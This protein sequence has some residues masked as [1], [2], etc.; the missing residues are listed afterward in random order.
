MQDL[1]KILSSFQDDWSE[2]KSC[3]MNQIRTIKVFK[4]GQ[5]IGDFLTAKKASN[6][7][8]VSKEH[9]LQTCH[10]KCKSGNGYWFVFQDEWDGS[11]HPEKRRKQSER[12]KW[13]IEV[14]KDNISLGIYYG[15]WDVIKTY[16]INSSYLSKIR[17][18]LKKSWKGYTFVF[19]EI[20]K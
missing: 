19:T 11:T 3:N 20:K 1:Q 17:R 15:S 12:I 5:F 18:G 9:I 7:C 4:D 14:F 6:Y 2:I 10:G 16:G 13:K 8:G